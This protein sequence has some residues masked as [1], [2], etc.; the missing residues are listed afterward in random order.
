MKSVKEDKTSKGKISYPCLMQ[1][2]GG[3]GTV[4]LFLNEV[5]GIVVFSVRLYSLGFSYSDWDIDNFESFDGKITL[6]ND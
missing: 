6:S 3:Q 4:V 2:K 5:R 1:V